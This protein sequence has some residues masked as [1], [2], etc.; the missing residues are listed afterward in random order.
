S[1]SFRSLFANLSTTIAATMTV[2]IGMFLLGL[3]IALG[4]WV[5]S[6]TDHVKRELVVKV[7]FCAEDAAGCNGKAAT[8]KQERAVRLAAARM[9]D[10]KNVIFVPKEKAFAQLK[11]EKP[12]LVREVVGNP[13]PDALTVVPKRGEDVEKIASR[14]KARTAGI[15]QVS[16][17]KKTARRVLQVAKVVESIFVVAALLMLGAATVL[18]ANTIRLSIFSRRR[19]IEVM[20]LV[21]AT[22]WFVRG[23]FMLEGLIC[24]LVGSLSAVLLLL[25]GKE[26]ALPAILGRVDASSDV[27]SLSFSLNVLILLLSGLLLG[28]AGSALTIRRFLRI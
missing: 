24:G 16:Y 3:C 11:K 20:K 6:W 28:A 10:V 14:F 2:L 18:V 9:P 13:L 22:N 8:R 26:V 27:Q 23:P 25:L 4:T 19:E 7:Y 5:V 12:R 1:E 15:H 17:G 21:G